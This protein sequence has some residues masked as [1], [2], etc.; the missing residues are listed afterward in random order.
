MASGETNLS[1]LLRHMS[2]TLHDGAFVFANVTPAKFAEL[3]ISRVVCMFRESPEEITVVMT[4]KDAVD[5]GLASAPTFA[6][7]T[8]TVHS[9]LEAVGLTA[10]FAQALGNAGISCNVVAAF[11]HDHIFVPTADASRAMEELRALSN[12]HGGT[13]DPPSSS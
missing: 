11:F 4:D 8:L 10:A 3:D 5:A 12:R 1:A 2:P 9:S 6:W 7:I 13:V